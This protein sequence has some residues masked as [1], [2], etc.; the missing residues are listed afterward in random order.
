MLAGCVAVPVYD[1]G[2][3]Y[4]DYGAYP[5][6]YVGPNMNFYVSG[7]HDGYGYRGGSYGYRGGRYWGGGR[8]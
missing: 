1:Y 5:Y 7:F 6:A 3:Y 4:P 8:R 2:Y